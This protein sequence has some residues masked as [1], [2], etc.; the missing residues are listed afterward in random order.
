[1]LRPRAARI[2]A[3]LAGVATVAV[4]AAVAD[5]LIYAQ[6]VRY[7]ELL[8]RVEELEQQ[9]ATLNLENLGLREAMLT[10]LPRRQA[11]NLPEGLPVGSIVHDF[12]LPDLN[13]RRVTLSGWEG[14]PVLLIFFDPS[15][16]YSRELL[17]HLASFP[18]DGAGGRPVALVISRG[19]LGTNEH[20]MTAHGVTCPVLLQEDREVARAY[21]IIGTPMAYLIDKDMRTAAPIAIG[22]DAVVRLMQVWAGSTQPGSPEMEAGPRPRPRLFTILPPVRP[23]VRDGLPPGTSAPR[24]RLPRLGGGELSHDDLIGQPTLLVFLDPDCPPCDR[25]GPELERIHLTS[26]VLSVIGIS[27]GSPEAN[28]TKVAELG[29]TFPIA[30]QRH[31]EVSRSYGMVAAPVAYLLDENG[32]IQSKVAVGGDAIANMVSGMM[33]GTERASGQEINPTEAE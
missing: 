22:P 28:L 33:V 30:L 2:G 13:G 19:G 18:P 7:G 29:L 1:M 26:S 3:T 5:R 11:V 15:C 6:L 12:D 25:L 17:P 14:R 8:L 23:V 32:V 16:G 31:W 24:F 4:A 21:G 20:L 10:E 9:L 27:R